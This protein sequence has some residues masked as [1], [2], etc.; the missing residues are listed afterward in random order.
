LPT[1]AAA[2][3]TRGPAVEAVYAT[4]TVEPTVMTPIAPRIGARIA[5]V[6][7]YEGYDVKKGQVLA[8]LE[9]KDVQGNL[10]QLIAQEKFARAD[11]DRDAR[12]VKGGIIAQATYDKAKS[13]W[14]AAHAAVE[15]AQAAAGYMMLTSPGDC[16]VIERDGEVGQFIPINQAVFW[17]SCA[18]P[19][20]VSTQVDEEDISLVKVGQ[21]VLIRADA[22]PGQ[23]F[24]GKVLEITPKGDPVARSYRV[25]VS[26]P[27]DSPL[28]IGMTAETNI[29]VHQNPDAL[30]VPASAYANG[31]VWVVR[32]GRLA[33]IA[34]TTGAKGAEQVEIR[35]G[36]AQSDLVATNPEDTFKDGERVHAEV[37]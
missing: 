11:Y 14:Q 29:V 5:Q 24:D 17:L 22:F 10:D 32:D 7:A 16:H 6:E 15:A 20:R 34:V 3:P 13:D 18:A 30:L 1:V 9:N 33:Q 36:L 31:K 35:G 27:Q 37:K 8:R 12:L 2:H 19:L 25:R 23:I 21:K 28:R 26:I 4:G